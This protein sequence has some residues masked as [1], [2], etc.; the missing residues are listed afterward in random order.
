ML[1]PLGFYALSMVVTCAVILLAC[2][3]HDTYRA[4]IEAG[5]SRPADLEFADSSSRKAISSEVG[6]QFRRAR[7][8]VGV[9]PT[10]RRVNFVEGRAV[11]VRSRS[12]YWCD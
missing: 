4:A 3:V 7:G 10:K 11:G 12:A 8:S 5:R 9:L 2:W 6:Q 1:A